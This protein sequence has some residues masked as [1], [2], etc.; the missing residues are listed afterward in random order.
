MVSVIQGQGHLIRLPIKHYAII[1]FDHTILKLTP[2][3]SQNNI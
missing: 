2:K 3:F 1:Y